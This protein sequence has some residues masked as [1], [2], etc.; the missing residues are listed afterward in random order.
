MEMDF[1]TKIRDLHKHFWNDSSMCSS[2][3]EKK[4]K[5]K[6]LLKEYWEYCPVANWITRSYDSF[7]HADIMRYIQMKYQVCSSFSICF[8]HY[9][10][11]YWRQIC[12]AEKNRWTMLLEIPKDVNNTCLHNHLRSWNTKLP[13]IPPNVTSLS[14]VKK[15]R[16]HLV[17][18]IDFRYPHRHNH[19]GLGKRFRHTNSVRNSHSVAKVAGK[20]P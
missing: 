19:I 4:K 5:K 17:I 1:Q 16:L 6:D 20:P 10:K 8:T 2:K 3:K 13:N 11:P 7:Q 14:V 18:H 12:L 15:K 9:R